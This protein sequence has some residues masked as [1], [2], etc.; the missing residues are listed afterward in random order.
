MCTHEQFVNHFVDHHLFHDDHHGSLK[1]HDTTTAL[2]QVDSFRK[3]AANQ[4]KLSATLFIDQTAAFDLV[5]HDVLLN[6]LKEYNFDANSL[7]WFSSYLSE[8]KFT[9]QVESRRSK[10]VSMGPQGSV[11]GIL[12]FVVTQNDLPSASP[13]STTGQ[14]VAFV[15]DTTD[16]EMHSNPIVLVENIQQRADN[17]VSWLQDNLMVVAP[18][19]TKLVISATPNLRAAQ[20]G[21]LDLSIKVGGLTVKPTES[22]KLL[23]V[24]LN[25]EMTWSHHLWG[26][27]W[28]ENDN[29]PGIIPQL[30]KRLG[31]LKH[32]GRVSS[33]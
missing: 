16:Q 8:R 13:P 22:E 14:T 31:L 21:N 11:L 29:L 12:L 33:T 10:E 18:H 30:I 4:R 23:G 15:D 26:E 25:Q 6:K 19:K 24:I 20:G 27:N 5:D 1:Y 9:V 2:L 7:A 32:L 3:E 28:L 17:L